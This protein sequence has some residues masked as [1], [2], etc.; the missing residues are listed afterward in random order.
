MSLTL[1]LEVLKKFL[2]SID[3]LVHIE[4]SCCRLVRKD[5]INDRT[6]GDKLYKIIVLKEV[7]D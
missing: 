5:A 7:C 4:T 2:L 3:F 6:L 1:T